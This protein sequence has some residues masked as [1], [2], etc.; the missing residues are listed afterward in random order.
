MRSGVPLGVQPFV[1][2]VPVD[3]CGS[4]VAFGQRDEDDRDVLV[5]DE[6]GGTGGGDDGGTQAAF[7][8]DGRPGQGEDEVPARAQQPPPSGECLGEIGETRRCDSAER[9]GRLGSG[10]AASGG[11]D[12]FS[13]VTVG[14]QGCGCAV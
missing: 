4:A 6:S 5:V 7:F 1:G 9:D 12:G 14:D 11:V 10:T 3:V 13:G 8:G 2:D